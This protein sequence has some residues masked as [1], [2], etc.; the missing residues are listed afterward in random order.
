MSR[1]GRS[2]P[3]LFTGLC[4]P[5]QI[6]CVRSGPLKAL[7]NVPVKLGSLP[8]VLLFHLADFRMRQSPILN[9]LE[10]QALPFGLIPLSVEQCFLL[11]LAADFDVLARHPIPD[12]P[13]HGGEVPGAL[14]GLAFP[15][16]LE[17]FL[18]LSLCSRRC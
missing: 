11:I 17:R 2:R 15:A 10:D 4:P 5:L 1:P 8:G 7:S 14:L 12:A 16:S 6:R 3:L 18:Q 13:N 9:L